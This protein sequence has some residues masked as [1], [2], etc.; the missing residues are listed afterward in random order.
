LTCVVG[1][2]RSS[3]SKVL[4]LSPPNIFA[5]LSAILFLSLGL[6]APPP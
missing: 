2:S 6:A 5:N 3:P 4:A 1:I